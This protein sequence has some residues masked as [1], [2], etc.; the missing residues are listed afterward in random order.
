M[1]RYRPRR[2]P[3][4]LALVAVNLNRVRIRT[5]TNGQ[6]RQ[7]LRRDDA[8]A[9]VIATVDAR[10]ELDWT[11]FR[12]LMTDYLHHQVSADSPKLVSRICELMSQLVSDAP[13][14][15]GKA[16]EELCALVRQWEPQQLPVE[17]WL[18]L[19]H[20]LASHGM[21]V[22]SGLARTAALE[23]AISDGTRT[24][25]LPA[26]ENLVAARAL[27]DQGR[28]PEARAH[29]ER[30]RFKRRGLP[31]RS[32]FEQYIESCETGIWPSLE[33]SPRVQPFRGIEGRQVAI[34]GPAPRPDRRGKSSIRT[35]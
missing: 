22:V 30:V 11:R 9:G 4:S 13:E 2:A 32:I 5:T 23:R 33:S 18:A 20:L 24:H 7:N 16:T 6:V 3:C 14:A 28:L 21:F 19:R 25:R 15:H 34:V 26:F 10:R 1:I 17:S 31:P 29:L 35:R 27:A 8:R 12:R